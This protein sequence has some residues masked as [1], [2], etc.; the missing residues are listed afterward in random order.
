M[1]LFYLMEIQTKGLEILNENE[2]KDFE[3]VLGKYY[4]KIERKLKDISSIVFHLKEYNR[5]GTRKKFSIHAK[6]VYSGKF[7]EADS[8]DWDL[9]RTIHKL[10]RKMEEEIEHK[11]HL[12]DKRKK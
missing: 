3:T 4:E 10:F 11:F 9:K 6:I 5:Q 7:F 12:S 2:K 8:F 1:R